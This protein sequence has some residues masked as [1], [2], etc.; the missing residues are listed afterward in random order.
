M[1][2]SLKGL[3]DTAVRKGNR[4]MKGEVQPGSFPAKLQ[5]SAHISLKR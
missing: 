4:Y 1:D 2:N 5:G 3:M